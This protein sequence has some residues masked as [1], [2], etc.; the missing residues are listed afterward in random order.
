MS[1]RRPTRLRS[2]ETRTAAAGCRRRTCAP[3]CLRRPR[4]RRAPR[5]LG[6][7][8]TRAAPP[9]TV[10]AAGRA[11][12]APSTIASED[13]AAVGRSTRR[14]DGRLHRYLLRRSATHRHEASAGHRPSAI[15]RERQ[16][17]EKAGE[18]RRLVARHL[19]AVVLIVGFGVGLRA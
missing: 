18:T 15:E 12:A 10:R 5:V 2:P 7:P 4:P 13:L 11:R 8:R 9:Q 1:L 14:A 19:G 17:R 16:A 6:D 3:G